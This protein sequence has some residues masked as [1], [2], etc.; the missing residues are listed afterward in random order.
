MSL[1]IPYVLYSKVSPP[2][3]LSFCT[4]S[5]TKSVCTIPTSINLPFAQS[6]SSLTHIFLLEGQ[7]QEGQGNFSKSYI[8][9]YVFHFD[10]LVSG[11]LRKEQSGNY[12]SDISLYLSKKKNVGSWNRINTESLRPCFNSA[13]TWKFYHP[14][15]PGL[16]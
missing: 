5:T 15:Q 11:E 2:Q 13:N 9:P 4:L 3:A 8:C 14:V 16:P 6:S 12:T 1:S 7:M 10:L